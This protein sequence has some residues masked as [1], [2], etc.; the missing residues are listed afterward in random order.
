MFWASWLYHL[1]LMSFVI[2]NWILYSLQ[3]GFLSCV[4]T[5]A[6]EKTLITEARNKEIPQLC[7]ALEVTFFSLLFC[8]L[9]Y[10]CLCGSIALILQYKD[11]ATQ[12]DRVKRLFEVI[13]K[14]IQLQALALNCFPR[15]WIPLL[16]LD[17]AGDGGNDVHMEGQHPGTAPHATGYRLW[18]RGIIQYVRVSR[19]EG[20][21]IDSTLISKGDANRCER[22][23]VQL[24]AQV[25]TSAQF[26]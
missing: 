11:K 26:H 22:S 15:F 1:V 17:S 24:T 3:F 2:K 6:K 4:T 18:W 16:F 5:L 20:A 13:S 23:D 7:M 8:H 14:S 25:F 12:R 21:R 10:A 19:E 9:I